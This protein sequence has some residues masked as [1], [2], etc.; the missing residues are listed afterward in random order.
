MTCEFGK[1]GLL[2]KEILSKKN[3]KNLKKVVLKEFLGKNVQRGRL[4]REN[5]CQAVP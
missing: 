5:L 3:R 2:Q 4:M 1:K